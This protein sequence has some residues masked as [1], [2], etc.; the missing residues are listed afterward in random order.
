MIGFATSAKLRASVDD[1]DPSQVANFYAGVRSFFTCACRYLI[2]RLPNDPC[3]INARFVNFESRNLVDFNSV[4][5]FIERFPV[6]NLAGSDVDVAYD[7][8]VQYQSL[9]QLPEEVKVKAVSVDEEGNEKIT[10][11]A[12][13]H[14]L[15]ALQDASGKERF[16]V[17]AKVAKLVLI[18]PHS[19]ADCKRIFSLVIKNKTQFRGSLASD[20]TLPSLLKCKVNAFTE[21][22]C[23]KFKPSTALLKSAKSATYLVTHSSSS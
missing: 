10:H 13:W 14:E 18:L 12:M 8:F 9:Q 11:D 1:L 16:S 21:T 5:Y 23:Y 6:L 3:V 2:E 4:L 20:K 19:N 22:P 17:I 15:G 7:Q